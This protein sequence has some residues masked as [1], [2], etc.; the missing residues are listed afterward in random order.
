M[1]CQTVDVSSAIHSKGTQPAVVFALVKEPELNILVFFLGY[2]A[3]GG[4]PAAIFFLEH[5]A[6][7]NPKIQKQSGRR[8][9]PPEEEKFGKAETPE[10]VPWQNWR[11]GIAG[12][13]I[14]Q[15][16]VAYTLAKPPF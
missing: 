1:N 8:F 4:Q 11:P 9:C 2:K 6:G 5:W 13:C 3:G 16:C 7:E 14:A 15:W 12:F 10:N